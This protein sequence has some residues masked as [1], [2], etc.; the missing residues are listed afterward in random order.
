MVTPAASRKNTTTSLP[1]H[2]N[3]CQRDG[4]VVWKT[5]REGEGD[6][7]EIRGKGH[8]IPEYIQWI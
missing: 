3:R 8:F 5:W 2:L 1:L 6:I 7:I 4:D